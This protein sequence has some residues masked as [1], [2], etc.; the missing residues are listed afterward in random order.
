LETLKKSLHGHDVV[1]HL[2]ANPEAREDIN[3]TDL[4]LKIGTIAAYNVLEAMRGN[5]SQ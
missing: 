2:A 3:H 5:E 1:W 4:D